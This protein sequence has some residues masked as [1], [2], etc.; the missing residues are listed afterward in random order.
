MYRRIVY[1]V[2]GAL[3]GYLV[4]AIVG[5]MAFASV[6]GYRSVAIVEEPSRNRWTF[7]AAATLAVVGGVI[8]W[9][10][11]YSAPERP[12]DDDRSATADALK[13]ARLPESPPVADDGASERAG[14]TA[15]APDVTDDV[16]P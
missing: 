10:R 12:A 3:A 5:M 9:W 16:T 4:G 8:A 6:D 15:I 11:S 13:R 1:T 2:V 14:E 7:V